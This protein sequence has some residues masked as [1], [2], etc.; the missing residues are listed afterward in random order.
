ML[1]PR[2]TLAR[3]PSYGYSRCHE[4]VFSLSSAS[5]ALSMLTTLALA[6]SLSTHPR[7]SQLALS[8]YKIVYLLGSKLIVRHNLRLSNTVACA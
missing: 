8:S 3:F 4:S 7:L 1:A 2:Q 6:L 5:Y